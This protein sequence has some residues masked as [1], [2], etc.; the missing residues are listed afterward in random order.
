MADKESYDAHPHRADLHAHMK[1][2]EL[3]HVIVVG[4]ICA[5]SWAWAFV[6]DAKSL[7]GP[8]RPAQGR[9]LQSRPLIGGR[10]SMSEPAHEHEYQGQKQKD[11]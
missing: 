9:A 8:G 5:T 2:A 11:E 10:E 3:R 1:K 4:E 7:Y 6:S